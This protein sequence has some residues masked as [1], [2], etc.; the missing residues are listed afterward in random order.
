MRLRKN[1]NVTYDT[2]YNMKRR[3]T[4]PSHERYCDYGGRGIGVDTHWEKYENFYADMGEKPPFYTLERKD[5]SLGYSK[6]NCCW[7]NTTDQAL[8]KRTPKNNTSSRKG[9]SWHSQRGKWRALASKEGKT[10]SLYFGPS[11]EDAVKA[12]EK[13]EKENGVI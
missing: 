11:F 4:D 8:N 9:I 5:N 2:W 10:Y 6:E 12:R 3:C 13:W 1:R 7:A